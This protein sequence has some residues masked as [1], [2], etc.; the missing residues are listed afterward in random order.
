MEEKNGNS[1][2]ERKRR[3]FLK[4]VQGCPWSKTL[5]MD[6]FDDVLRESEDGHEIS[7][8]L[9]IMKDKGICMRTNVYE[10]LLEHIDDDD[11]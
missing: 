9:N 10:L 11:V 7:E 5:W 2:F 6:G 1:E 3:A 4:C 8:F